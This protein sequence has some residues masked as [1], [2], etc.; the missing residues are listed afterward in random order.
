VN[1]EPG[2]PVEAPC[3]CAAEEDDVGVIRFWPC[4]AS[5]REALAWAVTTLELAEVAVE[6]EEL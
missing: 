4:S 3:G 5:H 1:G 2:E 6:S